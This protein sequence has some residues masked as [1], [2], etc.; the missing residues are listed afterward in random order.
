MSSKSEQIALGP[1]LEAA[2]TIEDGWLYVALKGE[3]IHDNTLGAKN[4]FSSLMEQEFAGIILDMSEVSYIHSHGM[5][6]LCL[7]QKM[8][9]Q[10]GGKLAL[11]SLSE[12]IEHL[13]SSLDFDTAFDIYN[14]L[15]QAR[16]ALRP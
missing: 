11:H 9:G 12:D 5:G 1:S 10:K 7:V 3:I 6:L 2:C 4:Y 14:D 8:A 15:E 16:Q 13:L